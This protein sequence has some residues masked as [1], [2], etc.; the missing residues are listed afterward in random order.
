VFTGFQSSGTRGATLV[1][2]AD[3]VRIFSQLVPIRAEVCNIE[4]MS[5]HADQA[6]LLQWL[7]AF[8]RPPRQVFI[9][10]GEPAA[11]DALRQKIEQRFGWSCTVPE[12]RDEVEL[13]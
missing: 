4:T 5:A 7:A 11:A 13:G 1:G 8:K 2:G 3:V 10:H 6:E 9:T 12:Y